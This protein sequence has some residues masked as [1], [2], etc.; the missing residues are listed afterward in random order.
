MHW[1]NWL[2]TIP[3][4]LRSLLMRKRQDAELD[5]ELRDHI[6][7]QIA[8]RSPHK[9]KERVKE[10]VTIRKWHFKLVPRPQTLTGPNGSASI[11][12]L[13]DEPV[14]QDGGYLDKLVLNNV[15]HMDLPLS[16]S[17]PENQRASG[18][19]IWANRTGAFTRR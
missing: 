8:M 5:E 6:Q 14:K 15:K 12:N 9:T 2:Y 4:R 16:T 10:R 19:Q 18:P 11:T 13:L 1:V 7:R 17:A 3:V